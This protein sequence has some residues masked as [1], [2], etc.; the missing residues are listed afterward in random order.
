MES[1]LVQFL[2][3]APSL[4]L[5]TVRITLAVIF[6]PFFTVETLG[7]RLVK[8]VV[9]FWVA[10]GL[11]PLI[12]MDRLAHASW[13]DM[14]SLMAQEAM[15][16]AVLGVTL[17]LPAWIA[18]TMG[19]MIDNQRGATISASIDPAVGIE[20]SPMGSFMAF[21]WGAIFLANGGMTDVVELLARSYEAMPVGGSV[22]SLT[23]DGV[24]TVSRLLTGALAAGITLAAPCVVAMFLTEIALGLLSKFAPQ[25]NAF[26]V[27]MC[28]KSLIAFSVLILYFSA[29]V[30][31]K[32]LAH[33]GVERAATM[34]GF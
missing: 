3:I 7:G 11:L 19:E 26:S 32:L 24:K 6:L 1:L 22:F 2:E 17:A 21:Y 28:I 23:L 10:V 33:S 16:G 30:P 20:T 14:V 34:W 18:M 25:L 13:A 9:L 12:D 8:T 4:A 5:A 31:S 15:V 29:I 27:A